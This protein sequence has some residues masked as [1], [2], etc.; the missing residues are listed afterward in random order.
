MPQIRLAKAVNW[1]IY[2]YRLKWYAIDIQNPKLFRW[3]A[4]A[5]GNN[6]WSMTSAFLPSRTECDLRWTSLM[7][8]YYTHIFCESA[9]CTLV[10]GWY[11]SFVELP[12]VSDNSQ[13]ENI[14]KHHIRMDKPISSRW[15]DDVPCFTMHTLLRLFHNVFSV[16]FSF[17]PLHVGGAVEYPHWYRNSCNAI[18]RVHPDSP[19]HSL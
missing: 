17:C 2:I 19:R 15:F 3:I 6:I 10:F 5:H 14:C 18:G 8:H 16:P 11:E 9:T 13:I 12:S 7:L 4:G 1:H